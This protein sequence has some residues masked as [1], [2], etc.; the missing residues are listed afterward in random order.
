MGLEVHF[1]SA[2]HDWATPQPL[3]DA[4]NAEFGFTVDAAAN[5]TNHKCARWYGQGGERE[6]ALT[7]PWDPAEVYWCNPPYGREQAAF[8]R[9]GYDVMC[10]GGVAVFLLPAR[11]DTKM[12]HQYIWNTDAQKTYNG[13]Q[14][15]FLRG[16]V[17]FAGAPG[18]APFPSMVVVM[19]GRGR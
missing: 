9:Q 18:P 10:R 17:R 12:F 8:V 11:T 1:S 3:F 19:D 5:A 4:L 6:D 16:R 13:V 15:R 2:K 7:Q 14:V